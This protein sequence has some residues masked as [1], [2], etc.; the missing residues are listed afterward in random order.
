MLTDCVDI[1]YGHEVLPVAGTPWATRVATGP[2]G[3]AAVEIYLGATFIDVM[4]AHSLAP[5]PLRG[6]RRV[7][8]H[9]LM[10]CVA[11][12]SLPSDGG[13]VRVEFQTGGLRSRR[14]RARRVMAVPVTEVCGH[15][16]IATNVGRF[17]HVTITGLDFRHR[18]GVRTLRRSH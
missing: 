17:D 9:G 14:P 5:V 4:V 10:F 6:A 12:G 8:G 7:A 3:R 1:D 18:C 2:A 13:P 15:F 16:W 11:W